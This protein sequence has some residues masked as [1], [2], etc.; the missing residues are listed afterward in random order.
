MI[1]H[2]LYP[3][4]QGIFPLEIPKIPCKPMRSKLELPKRIQSLPLILVRWNSP[5]KMLVLADFTI[6]YPQTSWIL[7]LISIYHIMYGHGKNASVINPRAHPILMKIQP[8]G[9]HW[10]LMPSRIFMWNT[11]K[12]R[13]ETMVPVICVNNCSYI[14]DLPEK[15]LGR[16]QKRLRDKMKSH[17]TQSQYIHHCLF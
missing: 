17:S 8:H 3:V 10:S 6:I 13:D 12:H 2:R 11:L 9:A 14:S 5:K 7:H 15:P 16:V 4:F 1:N